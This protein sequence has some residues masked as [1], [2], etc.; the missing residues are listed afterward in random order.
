[1]TSSCARVVR[2]WPALPSHV[3]RGLGGGHELALSIAEPPLPEAGGPGAQLL[4]RAAGLLAQ[5]RGRLDCRTAHEEERG[6]LVPVLRGLVELTP[7]EVQCACELDD[8]CEREPPPVI[9]GGGQYGSGGL[10]AVDL[11]LVVVT[12]VPPL[13]QCARLV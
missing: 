4:C 7:S 9:S 12:A 2:A 6:Y 11:L 10:E 5:R 13:G 3:A 8:A 1:M